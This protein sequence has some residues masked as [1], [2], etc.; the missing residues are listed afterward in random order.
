MVHYARALFYVLAISS[1]PFLA[2]DFFKSKIHFIYV[3]YTINL[4]TV[5]A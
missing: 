1:F 2:V 4:E 5:S 3:I